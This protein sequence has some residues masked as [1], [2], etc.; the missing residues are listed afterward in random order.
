MR[1]T[2]RFSDVVR[3]AHFPVYV[4]GNPETGDF[5]FIDFDNVR[6]LAGLVG[7]VFVGVIALDS[8]FEPRSAI[9]VPL[10]LSAAEALSHAYAR[11]VENTVRSFIKMPQIAN[12]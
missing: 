2:T 7:T 1:D 4:A 6:G 9:D 3:D 10:S 12:A 8:N 11:H 5:V